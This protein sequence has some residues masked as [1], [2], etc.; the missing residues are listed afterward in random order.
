MTVQELIDALNKVEDKELPVLDSNNDEITDVNVDEFEDAD[1]N[2]I[3]A[4]R[5][6]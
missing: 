3:D 2:L 5:L 6:E 1:E 4:V